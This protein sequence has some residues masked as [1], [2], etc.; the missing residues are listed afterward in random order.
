MMIEMEIVM[1]MDRMTALVMAAVI[2]MTIVIEIIMT[3]VT[4]K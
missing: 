4:G 3:K 1:V 2:V